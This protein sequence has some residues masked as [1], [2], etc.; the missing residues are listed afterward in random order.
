MKRRHRYLVP[1]VLVVSGTLAACSSSPASPSAAS[2]LPVR[3]VGAGAVEVK[4]TPTALD[5]S[6]AEFTIVLDTHS[7]D[8]SLDLTTSSQLDVDG[9]AWAVD[10]WTGDGPGGHHRAGQLRFT[11]KGS[12]QG[13][14]TLR[15]SGLPE[16]VEATWDLGGG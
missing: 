7:A 14:A 12:A 6:G 10:G 15:I 11:A 2:L 9:T 4:I 16:P 3:S 5:S 13:T 8:L 1:F